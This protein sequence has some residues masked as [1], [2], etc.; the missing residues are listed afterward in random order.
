MAPAGEA[1]LGPWIRIQLHWVS[2]EAGELTGPNCIQ[3]QLD[4]M[5][6]LDRLGEEADASRRSNSKDLASLRDSGTRS[7]SCEALLVCKRSMISSIAKLPGDQFSGL[8]HAA[9]GVRLLA[10]DA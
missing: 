5:L 4:V 9:G 8:A 3:W 6:E 1:T 2:Y 10:R 7:I